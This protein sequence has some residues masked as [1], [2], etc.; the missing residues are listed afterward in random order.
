[1]IDLPKKIHTK[2]HMQGQVMLIVVIFFLFL[3]TTIV[4]GIASPILKQVSIAQENYRSKKSYYLA[5]SALEDV[6]YRLLNSKQVA[7][8]ETIDLNDGQVTITTT[9]TLAGK[10]IVAVANV[11]NN[12]RKLQAN[13]VKG[14]GVV[15]K[16]GT[17]SGRGG[18]IFENN[19]FLKG[20]LYSNGNIVGSNGAYITGD[21]FVA[22]ST[23]SITNMRVGTS[24]TGD[25]RAHTITNSTVT[26]SIYCQSGSD[27]DDPNRNPKP[28]NTSQADPIEADMPISDENIA[29]WQTDAA[30]GGVATGDMT[31]SSPTT[32]GPKKIIGNLIINNTLTL[33]N[34]IWVTGNI[35]I[36]ETVK[37]TS[38][39]GAS[40][41]VIIADGYIDVSNGVIF[42]DSG[43]AGSYI[44]LLSNSTCDVS[45][46]ISPCNGKDAITIG[47]NS[48]ITIANAQKGTV[49][50]SNNSSVKEAA[51]KTLRLK[52]NSGLSYGS[53]L[54]NANFTS[55]PSGGY[56]VTDW[57]E[58][59]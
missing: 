55:G 33:S 47:N 59:Q 48:T 12:I 7:A 18:I 51:G 2:K 40:S 38:S 31:I 36:N 19:S 35:F 56:T 4:L 52:N 58:I 22:G 23:G 26:G 45:I 53:G 49:Y 57:G 42:Q 32:L 43:T 25:A 15:F 44:L 21:A 28:C 6:Y 46:A 17:Q 5:E 13:L 14:T 37:L 20:S 24:G 8:T 3:S 29:Q 27:N 30:D 54:V 16:Y 10:Q 41:G 34:T 50:F 11:N 9:N 1:M 39:Y